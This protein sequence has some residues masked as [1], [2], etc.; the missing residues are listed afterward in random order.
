MSL[1]NGSC[2]QALIDGCIKLVGSASRQAVAVYTTLTLV[3]H[4]YLSTLFPERRLLTDRLL[5]LC[6]QRVGLQPCR[7]A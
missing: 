1:L 5:G 6:E 3:R 4:I 7:I 2:K